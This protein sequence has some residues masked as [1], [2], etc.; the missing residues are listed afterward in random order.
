M[1][2]A[3]RG[4]A[5][6]Q[7]HAPLHHDGQRSEAGREDS[8][9]GTL[10]PPLGSCGL[11]FLHFL[12]ETTNKLV[13]KGLVMLDDN[14]TN[15]TIPDPSGSQ[16]RPRWP[17]ELPPSTPFRP[18]FGRA[19]WDTDRPGGCSS[20]ESPAPRKPHLMGSVL[21]GLG[22]FRTVPT[23][24]SAMSLLKARVCVRGS[25]SLRPFGLSAATDN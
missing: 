3:Q 8:P 6:P 5:P 20:R 21:A 7:G 13:C 11:S 18:A 22:A 4:L 10:P 17:S 25:S 9:A 16:L 2:G 12:V 23:S 24:E 19:S 1:W 15:L 14:R